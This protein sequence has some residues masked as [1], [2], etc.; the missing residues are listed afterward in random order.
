MAAITFTDAQFNALL[1]ALF[2]TCLIIGLV[3]PVVS[4]LVFPSLVYLARVLR[5]GL[6]RSG[7]NKA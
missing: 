5:V 1:D 6:H 2:W 3:P 7:K 4:G